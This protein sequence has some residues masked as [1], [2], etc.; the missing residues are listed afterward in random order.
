MRRRIAAAAALL[1]AAVPAAACARVAAYVDAGA[2]FFYSDTLGVAA[3]DGATVRFDDGTRVHAD[4]AFLNLRTD[5]AV[6]AGHAR[7]VHG[8][9]TLSADAIAVGLD[10]TRVDLLDLT[11]GA[12]RTTR[13]LG[14]PAAEAIDATLFA[15]PDV[16]DRGAFIRGRRAQV[17]L[18]ASVRISPATFPGTVGAVPVPSYLYTFATAAGFGATS[19]PGATFDQ[20]YAL[21]STP[22]ALTALHAQFLQGVGLALGIQQQ[23]VDGDNAYVAASLDVPFH[24]E[25]QRGIDA[26]KRINARTTLNL[27]GQ[28]GLYGDSESLKLTNAIGVIT[29]PSIGTLTYS[30]YQGGYSVFDA[31]IRSPEEPLFGGV[32]ASVRPDF[33]FDARHGGYLTALPLDEQP[34][35]ATVWYH[36]VDLSVNTPTVHAPL[37]VVIASSFDA[38]RTWYSYPHTG[39][40]LSG[41]IAPSRRFS[42]VFTVFGDYNAQYGHDNYYANQGIFY[43]TLSTALITPDGTPYYGYAAFSGATTYRQAMIRLQYTPDSQSTYRFSLFHTNDFPQYNGYGRPIWQAEADAQIRPF[44]NI[45]LSFGRAYDFGW[46]G[47]HV[48]PQWTLGVTP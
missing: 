37:G 12:T 39:Y 44:P 42:R 25:G 3:R 8:A 20:P 35:Y 23:L 24:G 40:T 15:F 32:T 9:T 2:I 10:D 13:A 36:G 34:R 29:K 6:F 46:G 5:Q 43:P 41:D 17:T 21:Y 19:L 7:I 1:L 33:G 28:A 45:G 4:A 38:V 14:T 11:N 22:H 26:Y 47:V 16:A 18:R 27:D 30:R 31:G 48:V